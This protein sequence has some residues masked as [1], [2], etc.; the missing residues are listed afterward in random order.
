MNDEKKKKTDKYTRS[1]EYHEH[2]KTEFSTASSTA[3]ET[4]PPSPSTEAVEEV[5]A[6]KEELETTKAKAAE[7]FDGWQRERADFQNYK[8]RIE[9]DQIVRTQEISGRIIKRYLAVQDDIERAL[10]NRPT[11]G[12]AATWAE[13]IEL[14]N[15]KLNSIL[16]SENITRIEAENQ[17]FDPNL[18]EALSHEES[19]EHGSG[20]IIEV[21]QQGYM[22]GDRVIRPALVRV[23]R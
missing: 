4:L 7:Y 14:V 10:K 15:R 1:S 19:G 22:L 21:I 23:A 5:A 16:E 2:D 11:S 17:L 8:R 12:E 9:R 3:K 13:G 20:Q 18:H 6:L